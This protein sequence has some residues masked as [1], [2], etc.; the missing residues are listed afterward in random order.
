[1]DESTITIVSGFGRCGSSLVMQML[2][3]GGM[4]V[5]G[6]YPGFEDERTIPHNRVHKAT[7]EWF[8]MIPGHAV[9]ILDPQE[10][11]IPKGNYRAIWCRRDYTEQAKSHM[12]FLR[13][14]GIRRGPP[15]PITNL[16]RSYKADAPLAWKALRDAGAQHI[17][18]IRFEEILF[19]PRRYAALIAGFCGG[20][21]VEKMAA[22][23][24]SRSPLCASG[25]DLELALV[26]EAVEQKAPT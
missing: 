23:V 6:L 2:A 16:V 19:S 25:L 7:A 10:A 8:A 9:K 17:M 13:I 11:P 26:K 24:K 12:K 22:V 18:D 20:L 4:P 1:M 3:A 15:A 14:M 5:T 21:D